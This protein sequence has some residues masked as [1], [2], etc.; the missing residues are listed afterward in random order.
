V[1]TMAVLPAGSHRQAYRAMLQP[2]WQP[3]ASHRQAQT[4]PAAKSSNLAAVQLREQPARPRFAGAEAAGHSTSPVQEPQEWIFLTTWQVQ[5]P[6]QQAGNRADY[7][8]DDQPSQGPSQI[9]VTRLILRVY[10]PNRSGAVQSGKAA[11]A[12]A[13]SSQQE[14]N[15]QESDTHSISSRPALPFDSGWLVIQL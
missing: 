4:R 7:E 6:A 13:S 3:E 14:L 1:N 9:T 8:T 10:S 2:A 5:S 15:Q 11:S 12:A